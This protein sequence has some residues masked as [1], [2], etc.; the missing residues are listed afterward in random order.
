[1]TELKRDFKGVWIPKEVWLD[2]RLGALDKIILVEIDSLD[3]GDE[4]GCYATN[5]YI[6]EFCQCSERKVTDSISLLIKLGYLELGKFD[7]RVREL[8]S[9]LAIFARQ[10]SK[11]CYADTQNLQGRVAKKAKQSRKKCEADT[12][13]LRQNNINNNINSNIDN[14]SINRQRKKYG[15]YE[16]VLLS[17]DELEKLKA[18]FSDWQERIER[19]SAYI[20]STGKSYKSHFA[21]IR[22]WAKRDG[23]NEVKQT[24]PKLHNSISMEDIKCLTN[25]AEF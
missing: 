18:E 24:E 10:G 15:E 4:R 12:Q 2:E 20:A 13:N 1:M 16:N 22:T 9:N 3:N 23:P 5:K 7:G 6:A 8:R 19:L 17:D 25:F 21:T 11:I 14:I